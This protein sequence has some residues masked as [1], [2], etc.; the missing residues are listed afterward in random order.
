M[1]GQSLLEDISIKRGFETLRLD[2]CTFVIVVILIKH[3]S[4]RRFKYYILSFTHPDSH[5]SSPMSK[6]YSKQELQ[7]MR[8]PELKRVLQE[9]GE[10]THDCL[11]KADLIQKILDTNPKPKLEP[12]PEPDQE[13]K[14]ESEPESESEPRA[15]SMCQSTTRK[16]LTGTPNDA[17]PMQRCSKCNEV[18]Y[19]SRSYNKRARAHTRHTNAHLQT[20]IHIHIY[21]YTHTHMCVCVYTH[22]HTYTHTPIPIHIHTYTR[23]RAHIATLLAKRNCRVQHWPTHKKHCFTQKEARARRKVARATTVK[24]CAVCKKTALSVGH[25]LRSCEVI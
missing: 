20:R 12:K 18:F 5:H 15:C 3:F 17:K 16:D 21:T 9:R 11:E 8:A 24:D 2:H 4:Q 25:A 23:A 1:H 19:C 22:I 6:L 10:S 7:R 13:Q 14:S